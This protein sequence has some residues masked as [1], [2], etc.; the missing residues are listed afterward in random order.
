MR[1]SRRVHFPNGR[2]DLLAGIVEIPTSTAWTWAVFSH[3]FTCTK[4][5]KAIVRIS[6]RL[7]E[8]GI[9]VLRYDAT[10]LGDS[11]GDFGE[12]NF[13]T[14][15]QDVEA[16]TQFANAEFGPAQLLVGHS[17]GGAAS[18][19]SAEKL[20]S[21]RGVA[22]IA[23]PADTQHL[24]RHIDQQNSRIEIDGE[25]EFSV[26]GRTYRLRRQLLQ[27]LRSFDLTSKLRR[28]TLPLIIFHSPVDETLDMSHALNLF[29]TAGGSKT[30]VTLDGADHLLVQRPNDV[31]FVADLIGTWL[32]R[33]LGRSESSK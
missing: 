17:F 6:R 10:G 31:Y 11:G 21:V 12:T 2:G 3:C 14:T 7:A 29:T 5:F 1:Q 4:D 16:A 19:A 9:G 13:E 24:A 20:S 25:G 28:L 33:C 23:A 8:Q 18:L 15:C 27:N 22:T 32:G 26:G 30:F